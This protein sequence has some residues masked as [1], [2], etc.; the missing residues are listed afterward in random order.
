MITLSDLLRIAPNAN[1]EWADWCL[2]ADVRNQE[3]WLAQCLHES[4]GLRVFVENLNYS[5]PALARTW[6]KRF[7]EDARA[8]E[9]RPNAE[10][11]AIAGQPESIANVV[12]GGR[13]GNTQPGDGWAYRGRGPIQVTGRESYELAAI[14][15]GVPFGT[16]PD[17]ALRPE[18]G[19]RLSVWWWHK[20]G[21]DE[22]DDLYTASRMVNCGPFSKPNAIPHGQAER[23]TWF[24]QLQA[25][26]QHE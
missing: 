3:I 2:R 17:I 13:M 16:N 11:R 4:G 8:I 23:L 6:P 12:Y 10:A 18:E 7:A 15:T 22:V 14:E 1:R 5:A 21:L 24:N 26:N 25:V 20:Y 9:L 19:V